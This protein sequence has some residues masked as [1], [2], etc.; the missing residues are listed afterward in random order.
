MTKNIKKKSEKSFL[1]RIL[2]F[3][4]TLLIVFFL[5]KSFVCSG[6]LVTLP[7]TL[8]IEG[9]STTR[10]D[11][12]TK[13][14]LKSVDN[15]T[16]EIVGKNKIVFSET[17]DLSSDDAI[18]QINQLEKHIDLDTIGKVY[19]D[20]NALPF[21]KAPAHI[22]MY[23]VPY[24]VTPILYKDGDIV[25]NK[26]VKDIWY[27]Y[28]QSEGGTFEFDTFEFSTYVLIPV[29]KKIYEEVILEEPTFQGTERLLL[30]NG[31]ITM[32]GIV[33]AIGV[34][35]IEKKRL[36]ASENQEYN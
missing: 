21:L 16:L 11:Q 22:S 14:Q 8:L 2:L 19:I 26:E 18:E 35:L 3:F 4:S 28:S 10:L 27:I 9:S 20:T 24:E 25:T 6:S 30:L 12:M 33:V 7:E 32:I 31:I 1:I 34:K 17:L 13:E 15:F 29:D 23:K 5:N 36:A